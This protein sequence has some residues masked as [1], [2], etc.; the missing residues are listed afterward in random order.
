MIIEVNMK[1]YSRINCK[2]GGIIGMY[3]GKIFACER[4]GTEFQLH[5]I[6]YDVLFPNN[7]TGWIFPMIEKNN[8]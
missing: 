3:D 5:K 1:R 7:K 4:C 8:E 6:N 2:C